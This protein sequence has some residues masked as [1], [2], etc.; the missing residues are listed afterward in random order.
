MPF[1]LLLLPIEPKDK[2]VN[3]LSDFRSEYGVE[4]PGD[5]W[6]E[7]ISTFYMQVVFAFSLLYPMGNQT[8]SEK[9]R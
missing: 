2:Q 5:Q 9:F 6:E 7:S 3:D 4:V 8:P 1:W